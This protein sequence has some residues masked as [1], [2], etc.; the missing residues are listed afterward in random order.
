MVWGCVQVGRVKED[1][2]REELEWQSED[3]RRERDIKT[4]CRR[5]GILL[6]FSFNYVCSYVLTGSG[7]F[8][9]FIVSSAHS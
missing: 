7:C 8:A 2:S 4:Q 3:W 1:G 9:V 5:K 6:I